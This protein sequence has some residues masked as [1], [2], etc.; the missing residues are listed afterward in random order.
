MQMMEKTYCAGRAISLF[1]AAGDGISKLLL[2]T[3][4]VIG[5]F[6]VFKEQ[7]S[8]GEMVLFIP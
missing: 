3:I 4:I 6:A 2:A 5:G 1:G 7:M 8:I